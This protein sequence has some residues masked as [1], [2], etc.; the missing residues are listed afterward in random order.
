MKNEFRLENFETN[1]KV[2][3]R[4]YDDCMEI[5]DKDGFKTTLFRDTIIDAKL[6]RETHSTTHDYGKVRVSTKVVSGV[7][8]SK[9]FDVKN[10]N[11]YTIVKLRI[12]STVGDLLLTGSEEKLKD[13]LYYCASKYRNLSEGDVF[14]YYLWLIAGYITLAGW[15]GMFVMSNFLDT[16]IEPVHSIVCTIGFCFALI[17]FLGL[18]PT[19]LLGFVYKDAKPE[20]KYPKKK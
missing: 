15:I 7:Y 17:A 20:V 12:K 8:I 2:T 16:Y 14:G 4:L 18:I 13:I 1:E 5:I 19:C 9:S 6:E 11:S 3:V 10:T